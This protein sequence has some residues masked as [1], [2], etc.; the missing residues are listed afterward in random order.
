MA[1]KRINET[2][3]IP[4][5]YW[6]I[7]YLWDEDDGGRVVMPKEPIVCTNQDD[8]FNLLVT[9]L[10]EEGIYSEFHLKRGSFIAY[11]NLF[12]PKRITNK[13]KKKRL[14]RTQRKKLPTIA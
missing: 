11:D 4:K 14:T 1:F 9:W 2:D 12:I 6:V 3:P 8:A 7:G 13:P 10:A 5:G